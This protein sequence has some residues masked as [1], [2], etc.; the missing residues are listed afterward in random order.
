M[1]ATLVL[2]VGIVC[3]LCFMYGVKVGQAT[4]KGERV[5]P[6]TINPLKAIREREAEREAEREKDKYDTI[7]R[8]IE[9]YDG[10]GG[11]QEDVPR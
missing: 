10:Y 1:E 5:E 11:N 9:N 6:P 7:M 2:A 8:N 4:S 3:V